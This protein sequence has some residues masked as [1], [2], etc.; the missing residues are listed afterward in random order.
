MTRGIA[1]YL[2]FVP[3]P[4]DALRTVVEAS[5]QLG[6]KAR[7]L[8]WRIEPD[9]LGLARNSSER[10][11]QQRHAHH[12]PMLAALDMRCE[13]VEPYAC[14]ITSLLE[15]ARI[16]HPV[17]VLAKRGKWI[18]DKRLSPGTGRAAP[19]HALDLGQ[20]GHDLRRKYDAD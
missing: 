18:P 2:Q 15:F 17:G 6:H 7:Q 1:N 9:R 16:Q 20:Y 8:L 11:H 19:R 12:L 4:V 13:L 3:L 14:I 10:L 5:P